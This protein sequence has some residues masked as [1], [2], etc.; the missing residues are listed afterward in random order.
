MKAK[1]YNWTLRHSFLLFLVIFISSSCVED[2]TES[3]KEPTRYTAN[4]IKS[5]S[6]LFDVFWNT[7]NQKYNYFYEQSSFNW[8]TVYNEYAPKFKKLK[9][10]NRDKQYSKAE[11]SEDCNKAIEYFTE[12]IDPIIDRHFYV[13]IS[14]P[15]SHSFIRN[16]YFHGG[17]K[18]KE[19]IYTYPFELKYEYNLKQE[20][21]DR[22]TIC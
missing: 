15:V 7:M 6:D 17:M 2:V 5:Y 18:S 21:S 4:D 10:F 11:I 13:K 16:V 22:P 8:E 20:Y 19:K 1:K 9:T 14:L 12:I 3:T